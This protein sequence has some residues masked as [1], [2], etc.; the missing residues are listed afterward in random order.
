M[1]PTNGNWLGLYLRGLWGPAGTRSVM[2]GR[3]LD[4]ISVHINSCKRQLATN[5][6]ESL[7]CARASSCSYIAPLGNLTSI[8]RE[9]AG[10]SPATTVSETR[11]YCCPYTYLFITR[12][13]PP[14]VKGED[15][16][17]SGPVYPTFPLTTMSERPADW[18]ASPHSF[19]S[20]PRGDSPAT[21]PKLDEPS[22]ERQRGY[23]ASVSTGT[24]RNSR[25]LDIEEPEGFA[26]LDRLDDWFGGRMNLE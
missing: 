18:A 21:D 3:E 23:E 4:V 7:Q 26:I 5:R 1:T 11:P 6:L 24:S 22:M 19:E 16:R 8:S 13:N 20:Q 14:L 10:P 9:R 12:T 25:S 17:V 15:R 2:H